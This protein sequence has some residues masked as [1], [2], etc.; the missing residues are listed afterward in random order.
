MLGLEK[1]RKEK[2]HEVLEQI[3]SLQVLDQNGLTGL[4]EYLKSL[5]NLAALPVLMKNS[6][7]SFL[8]SHIK[9]KSIFEI[10]IISM[11]LRIEMVYV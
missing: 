5:V 7:R 3:S 4:E 2:C 9:T 11:L 10:N 6:F 8:I 1:S